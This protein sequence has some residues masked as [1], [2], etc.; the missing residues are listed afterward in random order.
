[1]P[2][3]RYFFFVGGILLALIY[4]ADAYAVKTV[5]QQRVDVDRST[6]RIS[7]A[8]K[9]PEAITIDTSLPTIV[10]ATVVADQKTAA[11]S[12]TE[13]IRRAFAQVSSDPK[14]AP[15]VSRKHVARRPHNRRHDQPI[16]ALRRGTPLA[17]GYDNSLD[18]SRSW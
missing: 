3:F 1:M 13:P 2:L 11:P 12:V 8:R 16:V 17:F 18:F 5:P 7:S 6:I 15:R 10:P 14:P 9:W 4:V